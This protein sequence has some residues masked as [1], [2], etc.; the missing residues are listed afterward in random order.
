MKR[1]SGT[2]KNL[3]S[4]THSSSNT[5]RLGGTFADD[6]AQEIKKVDWANLI[7]FQFSQWWLSFPAILKGWCDRVFANGIAV[8]LGTYDPLLVRKKRLCVVTTGAK[9]GM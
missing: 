2:A 8:N 4:L 6:I 5:M 3:I 9:E 1:I 7:I